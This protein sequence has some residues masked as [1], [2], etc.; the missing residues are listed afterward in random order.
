MDSFILKG[1]IAYCDENKKLVTVKDGFLI[2]INGLIEGIFQDVPDRFRFLPIKDCSNQLII[3]GMTD[4]HIHAAQYAFRGTGMDVELLDWL[5]KYAFPE[6]SRFQD[7]QYAEKAYSIFADSVKK[8]A[9]TRLCMF[10]SRHTDATLLLMDKME[11][12]GLI[13]YVGKV[14][15]DRNAPDPLREESAESSFSETER[16]LREWNERKYRRTFPILTPR[17]TPSCTDELMDRLGELKEKYA[18]SVQSHLSENPS[19]I[20]FVSELCPW[21]NDYFE[22]YD[23]FGLLGN[24]NQT[25]KCI[26]AHCIWSSEREV[27]KLK[28]NG[29][30]VAHCPSSNVNVRSGI[31]PVKKYL[32]RG[33]KV[34]LGSDV[35]GGETES[36]F[37]TITDAI[38]AS[39]VYT[40]FIDEKT[41]P[42]TF[43][44]AFYL[45]T[46]GGGEFFG[47]VGAFEQG[48]EAD[49]IVLRNELLKTTMNFTIAERLERSVYLGLDRM[50]I[51]HKFV[52]GKEISSD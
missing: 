40:R 34:G 4:L 2:C 16:F 31:A 6:E 45:A 24:R 36:L 32:E 51:T 10:A 5:Q 27:D 19:E 7:L 29:V 26:M 37:S 15:M 41:M 23:Q 13:S 22:A 44:E 14:N 17:F 30:F 47:K 43:E 33:L 9:T 52:Q 50:G 12:S 48:Y 39:K 25:E 21:T 49:V 11:A 38:K 18:V 28:E 1:D 46:R 8:S 20:Q 42:L 3:P 35:A